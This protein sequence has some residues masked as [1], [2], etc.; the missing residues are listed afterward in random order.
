MLNIRPARPG[1]E[2]LVLGFIRELAEYEKLR[3]EAVAEEADIRAVLFAPEP[4]AFCDIAEWDG[5]AVG[6][7]L[8][9]YNVST[10]WGRHG[11]YLEDLYV[12]PGMRGKGIGKALL[13]GLARRCVEQGL[14]RLDWAGLAWKPPSIQ[15]YGGL[16]AEIMSEG[17]ICRLQGA[18]LENAGRPPKAQ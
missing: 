17:R 1:D 11:I 6:I 4:K 18:P 7:A 16:G 10:F 9:F 14:P 13:L 15:F 2:A 3:H 5:E 12:R 8:W